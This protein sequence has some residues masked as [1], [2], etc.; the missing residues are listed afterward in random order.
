[1]TENH[2]IVKGRNSCGG[3]AT[4]TESRSQ[5][6]FRADVGLAMLLIIALDVGVG[7]QPPRPPLPQHIAPSP[8]PS[9][10]TLVPCLRL[11]FF[12][13]IYPLRPQI[14]L[15]NYPRGCRLALHSTAVGGGVQ[16]LR[17]RGVGGVTLHVAEISG[18][19][20]LCGDD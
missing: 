16:R 1:M 4:E 14:F 15:Q 17:W 19:P 6:V 18:G 3:G 10:A 2:T 12:F 9:A 5:P 20:R 8:P 7:L 11:F 13:L